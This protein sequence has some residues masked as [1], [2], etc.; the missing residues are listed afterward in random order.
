[1]GAGC[2]GKYWD[3]KGAKRAKVPRSTAILTRAPSDP[4]SG[5]SPEMLRWVNEMTSRQLCGLGVFAVPMYLPAQIDDARRRGHSGTD[6]DA[7]RD[8]STPRPS[9]PELG[10]RH[11]F[12]ADR[13]GAQI[14]E[15]RF[16]FFG[17]ILKEPET[18]QWHPVDR[19]MDPE[20]PVKGRCGLV[21]DIAR[22]DEASFLDRLVDP[23]QYRQHLVDGDGGNHLHR[24]TKTQPPAGSGI[25]NQREVH[26]DRS[27]IRCSAISLLEFAGPGPRR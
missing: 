27:I 1:M 10:A 15:E 22:G 8:R 24:T 13:I 25:S 26:H 7:F 19:R 3:R 5:Y 18:Q 21:G 16:A 11:L 14:L 6:A 9:I 17:R 12:L 4:G 23:G 20:G 2:R